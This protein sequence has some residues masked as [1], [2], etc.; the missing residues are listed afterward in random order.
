MITVAIQLLD[1]GYKLEDAH[2]EVLESFLTP[3]Q[4]SVS[5]LQR[6][7]FGSLFVLLAL[8][9]WLSVIV[10]REM[11]GPLRMQLVESQT[12]I[13]RQEKLASLGVLAAGVAHEIRNP[14][15]AI[16]ARLF[17]QRRSMDKNSPEYEDS[18]VISNEINRLERIVKD[19][20]EFARPSEPKIVTMTA[21]PAL[22]DAAEFMRPQL[23]RSS[24][25]VNLDTCTST[26]FRADPQQLKQVLIN[27]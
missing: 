7:I 15:T 8:A 1:L 19:F 10:Y 13:E 5:L 4:K 11:I 25:A 3:S 14:L 21:E 24:I 18:T 26:P 27:L 6:V 12:I 22:R 20:L 16:K 2:R 23:Q 9:I 17:T